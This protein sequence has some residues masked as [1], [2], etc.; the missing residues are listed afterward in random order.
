MTNTSLNAG[1]A[2][3]W[4]E[5]RE[6]GGVARWAEGPVWRRKDREDEWPW[7]GQD[8]GAQDHRPPW[9]I[10][11]LRASVVLGALLVS[12]AT[13]RHKLQ[14]RG[15]PRLASLLGWGCV[16]LVAGQGP[17]LHLTTLGPSSC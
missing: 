14:S 17:S 4:R 15:R 16:T 10:A 6:R 2:R 13:C 3:R 1:L 5:A 8:R 9:D 12:R 7:A 11:G